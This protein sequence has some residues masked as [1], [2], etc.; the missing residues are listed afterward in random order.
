MEERASHFVGVRVDRILGWSVIQDAGRHLMARPFSNDL[1]ERAKLVV[2]A[3][4]G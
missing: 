1:C 4:Q 3:G 2:L